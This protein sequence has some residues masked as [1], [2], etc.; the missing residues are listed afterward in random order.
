MGQFWTGERL[1]TDMNDPQNLEPLPEEIQDAEALEELLSRPRPA[2]VRALGRVEGD[3]LVLGA[4]G[5]MGP[6][7]ARMARRA[8]DAAGVR[9]RVMGR[10]P[11]LQPESPPGWRR[12]ASRRSKATCSSRR[13][14]TPCPTRPT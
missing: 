5:K 9:R 12:T 10:Q 8:S 11:L 1:K 14:S 3:I 6:T 7:L 13:S 4:A 2:A